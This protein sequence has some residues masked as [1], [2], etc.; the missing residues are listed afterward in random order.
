[1]LSNEIRNEM[2]RLLSEETAVTSV[3]NVSRIA[4]QL[5]AR[6]EL[7]G[8]MQRAVMATLIDIVAS[9]NLAVELNEADE[10]RGP[11]RESDGMARHSASETEH[12]SP[13]ESQ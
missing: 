1:M 3:V 6:Y 2:S 10:Q 13:L 7:D 5:A 12:E 9:M 8:A 4:Q 11:D